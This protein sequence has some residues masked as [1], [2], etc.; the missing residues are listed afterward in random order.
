MFAHV[1]LADCRAH[2]AAPLLSSEPD[3]LRGLLTCRQKSYFSYILPRLGHVPVLD[4]AFC[5]L[6]AAAQCMLLPSRSSRD[7]LFIHYGKALRSL[8]TAVDDPKTRCDTEVLCATAILAMFEVSLIR[9]LWLIRLTGS[10]MLSSSDGRMWSEH[11]AGASRLIEFRG[12]SNFN[13]DFDRLLLLSLSYPVV[14]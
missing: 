11:I 1:S 9:E 10:Q 2:R 4:D 6:I 12:P 5:C 3:R 7:V 13:T 8:Q 14:S